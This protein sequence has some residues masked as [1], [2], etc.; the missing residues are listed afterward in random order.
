MRYSKQTPHHPCRNPA[1]HS[2]H[3][4]KT[5]MA[6]GQAKF[7]H[8]RSVQALMGTDAKMI[9]KT[10]ARD[11]DRS[12]LVH[13]LASHRVPQ[14][15]PGG[16]SSLN[17]ASLDNEFRQCGSHTLSPTHNKMEPERY[18]KDLRCQTD[19]PHKKEI[20]YPHRALKQTLL[21]S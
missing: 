20:R 8:I 1:H 3:S 10:E 16:W 19:P 4:W 5:P 12:N 9:P 6:A 18:N 14:A 13:F 11:R 17:R 2:S 21:Y 7:L 15:L